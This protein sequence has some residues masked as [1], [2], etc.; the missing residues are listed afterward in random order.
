MNSFNFESP[1]DSLPGQ[2]YDKIQREHQ[3]SPGDFPEMKKMQEMLVNHDFTKF[4]PLRVK[5]LEVVDKMLAVDIA[6]LMA[7]IPQ[8][9]VNV[10][11]DPLIKGNLQTL[12]FALRW[13][14]MILIIGGAF[15]G[16]EDTI[17]PFG[18]KRGEG[19]DAGY[20]EPEWIVNKEKPKYEEM[21]NTL[22][23]IDG[24]ITGAGKICLVNLQVSSAITQANDN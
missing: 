8:E 13:L 23:P 16:V 1:Y 21:F 11:T 4:Q 2:I 17:S 14:L 10:T 22:S 12:I 3:I 19:I 7:M 5:Q 20:G 15:D 6:Q 24:K 18:Y 9:E